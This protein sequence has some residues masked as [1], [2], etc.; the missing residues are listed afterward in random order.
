MHS[1]GSQFA[2]IVETIAYDQEL[3]TAKDYPR[4]VFLPWCVQP[5]ASD[6]CRRVQHVAT[7]PGYFGFVGTNHCQLLVHQDCLFRTIGTTA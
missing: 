2:K 6:K 3:G 1:P 5:G 7:Q 4:L